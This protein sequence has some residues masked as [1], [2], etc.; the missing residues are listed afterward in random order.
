VVNCVEISKLL[1]CVKF[2]SELDK[3]KLNSK[4]RATGLN[5]QGTS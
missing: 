1:S 4:F 5:E 3:L 2:G